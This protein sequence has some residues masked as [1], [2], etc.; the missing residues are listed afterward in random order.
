MYD[1]VVA[2]ACAAGDAAVSAAMTHAGFDND[3]TPPA[4]FA[5][6]AV[7]VSWLL[8]LGFLLL[9]LLMLLSFCFAFCC[10]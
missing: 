9:L 7:A 6:A 8:L 2:A 3:S 10:M 1:Y 4:A 5:D